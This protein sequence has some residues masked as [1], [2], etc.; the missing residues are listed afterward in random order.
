MKDKTP[1]YLAVVVLILAIVSYFKGGPHLAWG[2]V[3]SGLRILWSVMP[4]LLAAFLVAGFTQVLVTR[5]FVTRWLGAASGWR[6]LLLACIAGALMPGGPY[7][8]YPIAAVLFQAGAGIGVMVA[9]IGAKNLWSLS[10][11]SLEFALLGPTLT[12]IR[13]ISTLAIPFLMGWVADRLFR[14]FEEKLR[15]GVKQ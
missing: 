14:R 12:E 7:A 5:E 4:L 13:Y 2:G 3:V 15:G 6:G 9:F 11:L 1:L 10:R 8:Y